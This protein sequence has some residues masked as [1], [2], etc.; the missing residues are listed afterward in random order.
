MALSPGTK[1]GPYEVVAAAGAGGMGEVYRARDSRLDRDVAVK[2]LPPSFAADPERLRR[3]DQ[4][5][6]VIAA[7]NH[8]NIVAIHDTGSFADS[9]YLVT[10]M[11]EG[12]TLRDRLRSGALPLRKAIDYALQITRG[13][14]A[15]HDK[16]IAHRDLKPEN[17]FL[18]RDGHVKIL[19]FG[20]AKLARP[21]GASNQAHTLSDPAYTSPGTVL[22]TAGYMSPEQVRGQPVDHRSDIFSFGAILYEM[23]SG[24]RAFHGE[25]PADTMS[26]ILKDEPPELASSTRNLPP[27]VERIVRHCLEKTPEQR[28]QSARDIAFGLEELSGISTTTAAVEQIRVAKSRRKLWMAAGGVAAA[29]VLVAAG[30]LV[31]QRLARTEP[32]TYQQITFRLGSVGNARF[33]PD[34]SIVYSA[35]WDREPAQLY[36][37]RSDNPGARELGLKDA[38]ILSV[39]K[40]GELAVRLNTVN[41]GGYARYG[42]LARVPI[43]GG[44][45]RAVLEF[46]QEVDWAPNGD[47]F[48]VVRYVPENAHWRLEYPVGKVLYDGTGWVSH[49]KISPD[50]KSMAFADHQN[51][52]GDDEGAVALIGPDGKEKILSSGWV[53][54]QGIVWSPDGS[55]IWFTASKA[56]S[57][58]QLHGVTPSGKLRTISTAPGGMML[59]DW[60]DGKALVVVR[61]VRNS[62]RGLAPGE[63]QERELGW[64]GWSL[65]RDMTPDGKLIAFEEESQGGGPNYTVYIRATDGSPP[66]RLGEGVAKAISPDG[67][68]VVSEPAKGGPLSLVPTGAGEA[69]QLTHDK[70]SY[71]RVRWL[72][73][74]K[75]LLA[76]GIEPGHGARDYLI[77]LASGDSRSITPEG[78]RGALPSPDG[79]S[80]VVVDA[81]GKWQI[82]P[83]AGGTPQAVPSVTF[84]DNIVAWA[85]DGQSLYVRSDLG[86]R[87]EA[88]LERVQLAGGKREPFKTFSASGVAGLDAV[89][90][91]IFS[92]DGAAYAYIYGQELSQAYVVT[93]LK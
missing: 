23:I 41:L 21:D 79:R 91:P 86:P 29:L 11:L 32:P 49:P 39:S 84:K 38:E 53:A 59:E 85:P 88:K 55:E 90:A 17:I 4:E 77:D 13:L 47:D 33:T 46:V 2:V 43:S 89:G 75:Q 66:I 51:P 64:F 35:A 62:I 40:S 80:T 60:H 70:V 81:T 93:G 87:T 20:L 45:P 12:E 63:K 58:W 1:V 8:P 5:A 78:V 15:A 61:Q 7:L 52:G 16:G 42:T 54:L 10:E 27:A 48:A 19:D 82:W 9:R 6:R 57:D 71:G 34:G 56:G 36:M 72:P 37:A 83:I 68:W 92:R 76:S 50:G 74:D 73:G 26:S 14:A 69:R 31:G 22:G 28:F 44:S 3:F 67:K 65:L 24:R 25:T 18:T 30:L